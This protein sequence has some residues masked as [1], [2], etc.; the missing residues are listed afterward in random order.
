[1]RILSEFSGWINELL[2]VSS[3]L[4]R[5]T[6]FFTSEEDANDIQMKYCEHFCFIT[7]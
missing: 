3:N 6:N 7:F 2:K 4:S 1:M 5:N